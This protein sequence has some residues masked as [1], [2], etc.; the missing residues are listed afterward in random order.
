[1]WNAWRTLRVGQT[2]TYSSC[3]SV[4]HGSPPCSLWPYRAQ[5]VWDSF[6]GCGCEMQLCWL[7]SGSPCVDAS[8]TAQVNAASLTR[9]T[10]SPII[11]SLEG[12][13]RLLPWEERAEVLAPKHEKG[14]GKQLCPCA[15]HHL[16]PRNHQIPAS[17]KWPVFLPWLGQGC[18]TYRPKVTW[19]R[20]APML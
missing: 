10:L 15:W 2:R 5:A 3:C 14:P 8:Y 19:L 13:L 7:C 12:D 4:L 9:W 16:E 1:M 11:S 17:S 6:S 20:Q 18:P